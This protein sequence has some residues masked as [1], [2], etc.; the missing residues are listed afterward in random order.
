MTSFYT[1]L[2]TFIAAGR[3]FQLTFWLT[4]FIHLVD[5]YISQEIFWV[6]SLADILPYIL[7]D[8][9]ISQEILSKVG[10]FKLIGAL[11][12]KGHATDMITII[13]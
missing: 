4:F 5:F 3:H 7:V 10:L 9:N 6:V 2:V 8:F 12:S 1:S 11:G 13:C